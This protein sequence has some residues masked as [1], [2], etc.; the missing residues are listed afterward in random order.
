LQPEDRN[1]EFSSYHPDFYLTDYDIW[2]EHFGIDREGNVLQWFKNKVP[3]LTA[4]DYYQAGINW[5]RGIHAKYRTALIETYS[6]ENAEGSLITNLKKK[7]AERGVQIESRKPEEI[8]PLIKKSSYYEDFINLLHTFLGLMKSNAKAPDDILA[9]GG[10]RRLK[11]FMDVFK[12]I[13]YRYEAEL[14]KLSQVDFNDMIN[15]AAGYIANGNFSKKYKYILVDEF[16]DMSLGR[17]V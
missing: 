6:F 12:P 1:P 16:Q 7:L 5:K 2:H 15:L 3:Y 14:R 4:R 17:Y 8:L 9:K 11:V 13:Y 10:D